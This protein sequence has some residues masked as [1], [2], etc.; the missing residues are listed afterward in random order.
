M[1]ATP[2]SPVGEDSRTYIIQVTVL[3]MQ[4]KQVKRA[5]GS[6]E[7]QTCLPYACGL[8]RL[9][10]RMPFVDGNVLVDGV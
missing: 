10:E 4:H 3:I 2:N 9:H 5:K 1:L 8:S 6:F 7:L